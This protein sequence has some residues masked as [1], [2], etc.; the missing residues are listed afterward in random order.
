MTALEGLVSVA[1]E[2]VDGRLDSRSRSWP[3]SGILANRP[4]FL[5]GYLSGS[6]SPFLLFLFVYRT[7]EDGSERATMKMDS[8]GEFIFLGYWTS[9][10]CFRSGSSFGGAVP[11]SSLVFGL[12]EEWCLL[13]QWGIG[14]VIERVSVGARSEDHPPR[15]EYSPEGPGVYIDVYTWSGQSAPSVCFCVGPCCWSGGGSGGSSFSFSRSCLS[16]TGATVGIGTDPT[17]WTGCSV[18]GPTSP[19]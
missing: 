16:P 4:W 15:T 19:V 7:K 8:P 12:D 18:W 2:P 13:V 6:L 1:P 10:V 11:C 9:L 14:T 5:G 3:W 17:D